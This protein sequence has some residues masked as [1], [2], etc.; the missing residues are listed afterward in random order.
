M[1]GNVDS[2]RSDYNLSGFVALRYNDS[3]TTPSFLDSEHL[4]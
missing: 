1:S 2:K 3:A 4:D